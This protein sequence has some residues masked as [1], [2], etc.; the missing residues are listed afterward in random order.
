M[1][2]VLF[3]IS[4]SLFLSNFGLRLSRYDAQLVQYLYQSILPFF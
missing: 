2:R 1:A 4:L 3:K